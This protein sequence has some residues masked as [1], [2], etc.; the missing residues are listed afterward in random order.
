MVSEK[1]YKNQNRKLLGDQSVTS[2]ACLQLHQ[3]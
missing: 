2:S 3:T 1:K